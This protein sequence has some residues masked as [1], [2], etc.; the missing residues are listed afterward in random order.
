MTQ[1]EILKE[2]KESLT[3]YK[4]MISKAS[5][6][7]MDENI[8]SYPIFVV[9]DSG[10]ALGL[11]LVEEDEKIRVN[12]STLEEFSTKSLIQKDKLEDFK[13]VFKDPTTQLC[14]FIINKKLGATFVFLPRD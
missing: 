9:H 5:D 2:I 6:K 11:P 3:P 1:E 12:A 13:E 14:L 8:S 10:I 7:I 4:A